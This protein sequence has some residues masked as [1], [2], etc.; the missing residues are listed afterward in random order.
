LIGLWNFEIYRRV[1][2]THEESPSGGEFRCSV[3]HIVS[4][5]PP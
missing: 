1:V 4:F 3:R 5:L 2:L